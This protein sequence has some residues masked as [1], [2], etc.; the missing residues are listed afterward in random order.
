MSR[1]ERGG[2]RELEK[3]AGKTGEGERRG[4]WQ[5]QVSLLSPTP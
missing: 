5:G 4:L 1:A 2:L 3:A